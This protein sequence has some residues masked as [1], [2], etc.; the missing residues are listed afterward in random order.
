MFHVPGSQKLAFFHIDRATGHGTGEQKIRLPRQKG[1]DLQNIH[2]PSHVTNILFPMDIR[3]N[4][5][6]DFVFHPTENVQTFAATRGRG[7]T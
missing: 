7:T 3:Q 6:T 1:R 2:D 4:R 5:T